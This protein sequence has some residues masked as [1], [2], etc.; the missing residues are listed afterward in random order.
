M[1][2]LLGKE[3]EGFKVIMANF[4]HERWAI[5]CGVNG[6]VR[7]VIEVR[8]AWF[9]QVPA[10]IVT[11]AWSMSREQPLQQGGAACS[12]MDPPPLQT[13]QN[14]SYPPFCHLK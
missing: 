12:N 4:N 2:N 13:P 7:G 6:A 3:N 11:G 14:F 8:V 9:P 5:I 10:L 1:E